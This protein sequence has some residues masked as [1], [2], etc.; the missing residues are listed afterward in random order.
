VL[1]GE[2]LERLFEPY[3][4]ADTPSGHGGAGLGLSVTRRV[5]GL[6]GGTIEAYVDNGVAFILKAPV[7]IDDRARA[8]A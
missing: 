4:D 1:S 6:L 3:A 7:V 5:L 2:E 8:V